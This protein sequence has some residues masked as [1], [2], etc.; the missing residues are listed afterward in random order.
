MTRTMPNQ[1]AGPGTSPRVGT[2]SKAPTTGTQA[3]KTE[4]ELGPMFLNRD[5]QA[6]DADQAGDNALVAPLQEDVPP[7]GGGQVAVQ[8]QQPDRDIGQAPDHGHRENNLNRSDR[9]APVGGYVESEQHDGGDEKQIAQPG[10]PPAGPIRPSQ[11]T[12]I[13]PT[14]VIPK[15]IT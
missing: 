5:G 8:E 14:R 3:R 10:K 15:P 1:A 13:T 2:A 9:P 11:P 4:V 12:R 7:R 6:G